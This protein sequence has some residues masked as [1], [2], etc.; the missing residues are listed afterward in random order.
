MDT[1]SFSVSQGYST[2]EHSSTREI[3]SICEIYQEREKRFLSQYGCPSANA[4]PRFKEESV[5]SIRTPFQLDRDRIVYSNAFR[6]LKHK[7]QVFLS[8]LGDHYRTRLTHTLEVSEIARNIARAMR[9]N[10]DLA[11]AIALGHDLGHTPFGHGGETA[12]KEIYSRHFSHNSQSLRVV[13]KLEKRGDG[14]NLTYQV[15]DGILKH[16]KGFGEIMPSTPGNTAITVEGKI[17]RIADIIA[18]LNHDLDDALRSKVIT[19]SEI[20]EIC[21]KQLG[22]T[23]SERART[24]MQ[25]I[26]SNSGEKNIGTETKKVK[27]NK[28]K[29]FTD[30]NIGNEYKFILYMGDETY[31]AM[32]IL[33]QF[34]Y[35]KVYRA[36]S[37]HQEFVKAK[38]VLIELYNRF[39]VDVDLLQAELEKMEMAPWDPEKNSLERSVCDIIA[40]MTDRYALE[41]YTRLFFPRPRV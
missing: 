11:E 18:Y 5:C 13:D 24:M 40:S 7:T 15:R 28:S 38:K 25:D 1:T 26:I 37:V 14:L 34:L 29:D 36:P 21:K 23:H 27:V 32:T 3:P 2:Y 33:R 4:G 10:E 9:L 30:N 31:S 39:M 16:S 6:R 22:K 41:L 12:L 8:P 20:P 35:N 19:E 17:V